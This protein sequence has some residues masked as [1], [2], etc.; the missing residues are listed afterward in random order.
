VGR[1]TVNNQSINQLQPPIRSNAVR[2][3]SYLSLERPWYIDLTADCS[4]YLIW[5][6]WWRVWPINRKSIPLLD[7]WSHLW[8][9]QRSVFANSQ[10]CISYMI[11]EI[12]NWLLYQSFHILHKL[13][14][15]EQVLIIYHT[16]IAI[17][18]RVSDKG[19]SKSSCKGQGHSDRAN[20]VVSKVNDHFPCNPWS[21]SVVRCS[22]GSIDQYYWYQKSNYSFESCEI[23]VDRCVK[24]NV[25]ILHACILSLH[26]WPLP[27]EDMGHNQEPAPCK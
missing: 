18:K 9:I 14:I 22:S 8:Y 15:F 10:I 12:D 3:V 25:P 1:K 11:Q 17:S 20:T 6:N 5:K 2:C 16:N 19:H 21:S 7:T 24:W 4:I 23:Y 13:E 27:N 26:L